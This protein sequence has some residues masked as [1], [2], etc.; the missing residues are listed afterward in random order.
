MSD[1][2][3][4]NEAHHSEMVER[5]RELFRADG[6]EIVA[7][8]Y[9][10]AS[11]G[12]WVLTLTRE[13]RTFCVSSDVFDN[14]LGLWL[15]PRDQP[16]DILAEI[17]FNEGLKPETLETVRSFVVE[18]TGR[19]LR[20]EVIRQPFRPWATMWWMYSALVGLSI[21]ILSCFDHGGVR[22]LITAAAEKRGESVVGL[23][24]LVVG[25]VLSAGMAI[26]IWID[27]HR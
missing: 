9:S 13:G 16:A 26:G 11:F 20:G 25:V 10:N 15:G 12:L 21:G 18:Q 1:A 22:P 8:E 7:Q 27:Q 14:R 19:I 3:Q 23:A 2:S 4:D 17:R 6:I 5:L 24:L